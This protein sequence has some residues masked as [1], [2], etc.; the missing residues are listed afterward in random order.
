MS[1]GDTSDITVTDITSRLAVGIVGGVASSLI[2]T[3]LRTALGIGDA[4]TIE[5][6]IARIENQLAAINAELADL[7]ATTAKIYAVTVIISNQVNDSIIQPKLDKFNQDAGI[8]KQYFQNYTDSLAALTSA[9]AGQRSKAEA[10]LFDLFS[11]ATATRIAIA[12]T[13]IQDAFLP[14]MAEAKGIIDLQ[15]EILQTQLDAIAADQENFFV[16]TN[17]LCFVTNVAGQEGYYSGQAMLAKMQD[18]ARQA[19]DTVVLDTFRAFASAALQGLVLLAAA[20]ENTPFKAQIDQQAAGVQSVLE[21]MKAFYANV[22]TMIDGLVSTC[23]RQYGKRLRTS[24]S[25][26]IYHDGTNMPQQFTWPDSWI[27]WFPYVPS[28][29][30][31]EY[32]GLALV[33]VE[34]PWD[35]GVNKASVAREDANSMCENSNVR[36]GDPTGFINFD[37]NF[38]TLK[39]L[40]LPQR[41]APQPGGAM[42]AFIAN[43]T[44]APPAPPA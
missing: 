1:D 8:I 25:T 16:A 38:P 35:Y 18:A 10:T 11:S 43:L 34:N 28:T 29:Q 26:W 41:F 32:T 37:W 19:L 20:W 5:S 2:S 13:A 14:Q 27:Q 44:A 15:D 17:I 22:G 4:S 7:Q 9:E 12:L 40:A 3:Q 33:I 39:P 23:L 30:P 36:P 6:Y 21:A 24:T 31:D 42:D